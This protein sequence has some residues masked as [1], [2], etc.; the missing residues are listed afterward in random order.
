MASPTLIYLSGPMATFEDHNRPAFAAAAQ[1]LR[2]ADYSVLSPGE[3]PELGD[4]AAWSD[5]LR[6]DLIT[7]LS[8]PVSG[9]ARLSGWRQSRGAR[10]EC[11]VARRLGIPVMDLG[12]W[13][14]LAAAE[15]A[16]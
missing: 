9:V 3:L 5:Y 7:M 13:L 1:S 10:L 4:N 2:A 15:E 14:E 8:V 12:A 6:R 11:D 16:A